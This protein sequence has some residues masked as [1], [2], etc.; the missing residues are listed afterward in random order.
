MAYKALPGDEFAP[1]DI[2]S[3]YLT[4]IQ[5]KSPTA[6]QGADREEP[7]GCELSEANSS[8]L[9]CRRLTSDRDKTRKLDA[10][11]YP[12]ETFVPQRLRFLDELVHC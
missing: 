2:F 7:R 4:V 12:R 10:L 6:K 3:A 11:V 5:E 8:K 9:K 1:E